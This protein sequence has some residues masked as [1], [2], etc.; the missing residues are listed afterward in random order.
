MDIGCAAP[1]RGRR[2]GRGDLFAALGASY[3]L[4]PLQLRNLTTYT[5]PIQEAGAPAFGQER[6]TSLQDSLGICS[7]ATMGRLG[8][9]GVPCACEVDVLGT[10]TMHSLLLAAESP[11]PWQTGTTA[12][13]VSQ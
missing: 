11:A 12:A 2:S 6:A 4:G 10:L 9:R 5:L 3:D 7:C 1:A 8:D 13:A